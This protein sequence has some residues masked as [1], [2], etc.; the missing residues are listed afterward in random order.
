[1]TPI[2]KS[3]VGFAKQSAKCTSGTSDNV[4]A[5]EPA[6]QYM[7]FTKGALASSST[8]LPLDPEVGG[9]S[10]VRNITKV[11]VMSGGQ[12]EFIPRPETLGH[13]LAGIMGSDTS[14]LHA[15][16]TA[17][18]DHV[19][20]MAADQFAT[21]YYTFR[22]SP[23]YLWGEQFQDCKVSALALR[24][25]GANFLRGSVGITGGLPKNIATT[26][27]TP[28]GASLDSGPQFLAPV[29]TIE[30]PTAAAVKCLEGAFTA[31]VAIPMDNQWIVGS[32]SPDDFDINSRIFAVNLTLK[33]T[34][35]TLYNK[36]MYDQAGGSAWA[37]D[38]LREGSFKLNFKSNVMAETTHPYELTIAGNGTAGQGGNVAW[39]VTPINMRPGGQVTMSVTGMFL[40]DSTLPIAV[41]L[42]NKHV[43]AYC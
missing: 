16:A 11:G 21:P 36:M 12:L 18:Y 22:A 27:W 26:A 30:L 13:I 5:T 41:T 38:M 28:T 42:T 1:M 3:V 8:F 10:L 6:Y 23:G 24:W 31:A 9:G 37:A 25:Q 4:P 17:T 40:A 2:E 20:K 19:L 29:S 39:S 32:Y 7:L 15:T 43:A 34:D 33:I 14:T 35:G